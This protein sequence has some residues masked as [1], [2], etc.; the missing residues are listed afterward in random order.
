MS[1][2]TPTAAGRVSAIT[3]HAEDLRNDL[4][5]VRD[6][7][8]YTCTQARVLMTYGHHRDALAAMATLANYADNSAG[9]LERVAKE[10]RWLATTARTA[11]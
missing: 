5:H 10:L 6:R 3:A 4:D 9:L 7:L 2:S 11:P 8:A 1:E